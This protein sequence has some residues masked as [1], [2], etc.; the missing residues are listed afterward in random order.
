[1]AQVLGAAL[2]IGVVSVTPQ[3]QAAAPDAPTVLSPAA[4][5]SVDGLVTLAW[6]RPSGAVEFDVRIDDAADFATPL[7]S[8]SNTTNLSHVPTVELPAGD[9]WWQV[10]AG[11]GTTESDWITES[12][13]HRAKSAPDPIRPLAGAVIQP[14]TDTPRFAWRPVRGAASY[15]LE[16]SPDRYFTDPAL[17]ISSTQKTTAAVLTGYQVPGPY[18]WRVKAVLSNGYSTEWSPSLLYTVKGLPAATHASPEDDNFDRPV[19]EVV[20]DWNPVPGAVSYDLEIGTDINFLSV[21]HS[22]I[23]SAG[24]VGTRY[25][26]PDGLDNDEY[27]WRVRPVDASGNKAPWPTTPWRFR[28][29]WPDQPDLV[30]PRG[31]VVADVPFFYQWDAIEMAS[32]Y[33]V[34]LYADD[35]RQLCEASTVHTTLANV[36]LPPSAGDY[37]WK[38]LARDTGGKLPDPTTDVIGH[39]GA[40]FS[41]A[42]GAPVTGSGPLTVDMVTGHA[43]SMNGTAAYG[44]GTERDTCTA[45]CIN[46]RQM[47][48]LT[49]DPVPGAVRYRLTLAR[50]RELTNTIETFLVKDP[51]WTPTETLA[52]SQAGSAYFWMV[53]PC[54][55]TTS[56]A[57]P[58][59]ASQSFAKETVAPELLSPVKELNEEGVWVP[60]HVENDVTLRWDTVLAAAQA[61]D[62]ATDSSLKTPA[63]TDAKSYL[64]E[65]S[66]DRAFDSVLERVTV[67]QTTFTSFASTYPEGTVYWRVR[68]IDGSGNPMVWSA[69]EEFEKRSP[70]PQLTT[71]ADGDELGADYAFS[72]TPLAYAA[73]YDI[74]IFAGPTRVAGATAWKHASWAPSDPLPASAEGYT[75]RVRRVDAQGRR[76]DWSAVRTVGPPSVVPSTIAPSDGATVAP[77]TAFFSWEPDDRASSYRFERRLAGTTSLAEN[78]TTRSSAWAPTRPLP[79]G[80]WEWRVVTLDTRG[81][82]LGASPWSE[83]VVIDPPAVVTPVSISGSGEVGT[84][85]RVSAPTFDPQVDSISYQWYR[86]TTKLTGE[87][88]ELYTV[89]GADLGKSMTVQA[90]GVLAGY[91]P[92]VTTSG[93][94][95]GATGAALVAAHP[96][97]IVGQATVGQTL[98]LDQGVWPAEP[99]RTYQWYRAGEAIPRAT[100]ASYRL[101][102]VDAGRQIHVVETATVVGR[103]P[104]TATS[105]AVQVAKLPSTT[106]LTLS[107]SRTTP[108]KRVTAS[109]T[110]L[111]SGLSEPGGSVTLHDGR[112]ALKTV[113]LT[114]STVQ[115][116]LPRLSKGKHVIKAVYNGGEQA[117]RSSKSARLVVR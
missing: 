18:Y 55:T 31:K 101:L 11:D 40:S 53:Q 104:G 51:I 84:E 10:R 15:K 86:G 32:T 110:V 50:D 80:T 100:G 66:L 35:G 96:P 105:S 113:P 3:A 97:S 5:E 109:V 103:T 94:I 98:T 115:V 13:S 76:G 75:W 102:P 1:M 34:F 112:R 25:S 49:W 60:P 74:D 17:V 20:L 64:V 29:A 33:T 93:P 72:W 107:A 114:T 117:K 116:K 43:A 27:Y 22:R 9:L 56:C 71:P 23:N 61:P 6:N 79:A 70:I 78:I 45:T 42:P 58:Q 14:P 54:W 59:H 65:T 41:Y 77:S 99:K 67:D 83:F 82:A 26:P 91:K 73:S 7:V 57:P 85:L 88:G 36:C 37:T 106:A 24:V 2:A 8:I 63:T 89:T 47:P 111:V 16:V 44:I 46:V 30:H 4:G 12:F 69:T 19:R 95:G 39:P 87:T 68:A 28:R 90:T 48:V 92:A 81:A 38:V 21:V 52:D 108:R 62:A